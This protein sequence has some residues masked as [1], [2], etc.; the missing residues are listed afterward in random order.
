MDVI[1]RFLP[2]AEVRVVIVYTEVID[3]LDIGEVPDI[4]ETISS[5]VTYCVYI[6][7]KKVLEV[8]I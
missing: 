4:T 8:M 3:E 6:K 2:D 7:M 5:E 1:G